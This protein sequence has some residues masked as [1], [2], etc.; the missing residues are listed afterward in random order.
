MHCKSIKLHIFRFKQL[1]IT[2]GFALINIKKVLTS[3]NFISSTTNE[4]P[5]TASYQRSFS[6]AQRLHHMVSD[7]SINH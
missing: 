5:V 6:Q 4:I 3:L 2:A 1:V 7:Q